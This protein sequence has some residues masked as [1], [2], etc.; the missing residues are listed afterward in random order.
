MRSTFLPARLLQAAMLLLP[1]ALLSSLAPAQTPPEQNQ[2]QPSPGLKPPAD[3]DRLNALAHKLLAAALKANAL[4]GD[5]LKPWHAKI[6]YSLLSSY[7]PPDLR[8]QRI[9]TGGGRRAA[10]TLVGTG[11]GTPGM[12]HGA[13]EEWHAARYQW[14]RTYASRMQTWNGAEWSVS[15]T[16]RFEAKPKHMDFD[17]DLLDLRIARPILDPLYQAESLPP[18]AELAVSRLSPGD[19]QVFNCVLLTNPNK[20][21]PTGVAAWTM[22]TMCFDADLRLR[23]V[24]SGNTV[25]QFSDFQPFQGRSVARAVR[26]LVN[27]QLDSE[28]KITLLEAFDP[29]A[30]PAVLKPSAAA[31]LQPYTIESG[32][33]PLESIHEQGTTIPLLGDGTPFRGT[34]T[35]SAIVRKDGSVKVMPSPAG[36]MQPVQDAV[37]LAVSKWKYKPYLI[38]GRPVEVRVNIPYL[39]DGKPFVP[40]YQRSRAQGAYTP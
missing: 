31:V 2:A 32:D 34:L 4:G 39:I 37:S 17:K 8:D 40:S 10:R 9:G 7:G 16:G 24:S 13:V 20:I 38:D 28:M 25:V 3:R 19:G 5:D 26:V 1:A 6:E 22:P 35:V 21:A 15:H 12:A 11:P 36:P 29:A 33:P 27:N 30:N 14:S 18:D 23:L